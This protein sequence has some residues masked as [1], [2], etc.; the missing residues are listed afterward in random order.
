MIEM[1]ANTLILA[2]RR[3]TWRPVVLYSFIAL[4]L[5]FGP[6]LGMAPI[7]EEI[8]RADLLLAV[9]LWILFSSLWLSFTL[10]YWISAGRVKYEVAAGNL[11][12]YR[13]STEIYR[14]A[15]SRVSG[16]R[17]DGR[18]SWIQMLTPFNIEGGFLPRLIVHSTEVKICPA[19][20][21]WSADEI[22]SAERNLTVA[23]QGGQ[24]AWS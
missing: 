13:G 17:L 4:P 3:E 5:G 8:V 11:V 16:L 14:V 22:S 12:V 23:V 2:K 7:S 6:V 1:T 9:G 15:C 19:I 20:V 18:P 21:I 10:P 24:T